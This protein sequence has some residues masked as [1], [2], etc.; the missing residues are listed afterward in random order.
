VLPT[1]LTWSVT[2]GIDNRANSQQS[3]ILTDKQ[4][5]FNGRLQLLMKFERSLCSRPLYKKS[6]ISAAKP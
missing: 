2:D 3:N 1:Q 4:T 5:R 6:L